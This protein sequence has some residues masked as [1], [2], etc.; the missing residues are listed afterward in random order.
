[1]PDLVCLWRGLGEC[2]GEDELGL[3]RGRDGDEGFVAILPFHYVVKKSKK[4]DEKGAYQ[5]E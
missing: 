3:E 1:M 5:A 4:V 2:I